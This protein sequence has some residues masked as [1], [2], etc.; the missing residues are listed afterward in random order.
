M[1]PDLQGALLRY[2][3]IW[4]DNKQVA[5][6]PKSNIWSLKELAETY[7]LK[8]LT[9]L[10][11]TYVS[12]MYGGQNSQVLNARVRNVQALNVLRWGRNVQVQT[13][14]SDMTRWK[15][16]FAWCTCVKFEGPG[17]KISEMYGNSLVIGSEMSS[18][19]RSG[20]ETSRSWKVWNIR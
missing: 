14:G 6:L 5:F 9:P 3:Q 11:E 2:D 7:S 13:S 18:C 1:L 15:L 10:S 17:S 20:S 19:K 12:D 4:F 8:L 16:T